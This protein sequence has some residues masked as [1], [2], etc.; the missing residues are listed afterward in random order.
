MKQASGYVWVAALS[1]VVI[2]LAMPGAAR[3]LATTAAP[4]SS[5]T[6]SSSAQT[7]DRSATPDDVT[8]TDGSTLQGT[9]TGM[10]SGKLSLK[11]KFASTI[12]VTQGKVVTINTATV[13]DV[14]MYD[15][16]GTRDVLAA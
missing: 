2:T 5:G 6:Q 4:Q 11:N 14:V 7:V 13:L 10:L 16:R 3:A 9:I 8:T 15:S 12:A 1:V